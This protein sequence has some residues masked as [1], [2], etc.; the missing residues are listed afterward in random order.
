[1]YFDS[2]AIRLKVGTGWTEVTLVGEVGVVATRRGYVPAI[3]VDRG[4]VRHLFLVGA[5]SLGGPLE[6]LRLKMGSL[7][8]VCI[9]I[10][11][12]GEAPTSPYEVAVI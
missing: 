2:D 5:A 6:D 3:E 12:V 11:K 1:M 7:D 9:K 10:R 4:Q 8:G